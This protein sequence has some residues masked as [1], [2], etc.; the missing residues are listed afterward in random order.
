LFDAAVFGYTGLLLDGGLVEKGDGRGE[1]RNGECRW[2]D[3]RLCDAVKVRKNLV[4]HRERIVE[5]FFEG[6][7]E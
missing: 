1:G 6:K 2:V 3:T 4:R 5:R 7:S